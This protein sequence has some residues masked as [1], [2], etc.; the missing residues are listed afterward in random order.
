MRTDTLRYVILAGIVAA[1]TVGSAQTVVVEDLGSPQGHITRAAD[2]NDAGQVVGRGGPLWAGDQVKGFIRDAGGFRYLPTLGGGETWATRINAVG[3]VIGWGRVVVD[4]G[5]PPWHGFY[6]DKQSGIVD[7]GT[8]YG[9]RGY[10]EAKDINNLGQ[11]TGYAYACY[12]MCPYPMVWEKGM[13]LQ[14]LPNY[15]MYTWGEGINDL[16]TIIANRTSGTSRSL[17]WR[18]GLTGYEG[19]V[20]L[21]GTSDSRG[22]LVLQ[23]NRVGQ[24]LGHLTEADG[25]VK[26]YL[27]DEGSITLLPFPGYHLVGSAHLNNLGQVVAKVQQTVRD[28]VV[29]SIVLWDGEKVVDLGSGCVNAEVVDMNDYTQIAATCYVDG[30]IHGAVWEQGKWADLGSLG[31]Y[32]SL[33]AMNNVGQIVGQRYAEDGTLRATLWTVPASPLISL[34]AVD[35][36]GNIVQQFVDSSKLNGPEGAALIRQLD[37]VKNALRD[38]RTEAAC[39]LLQAFSAEVEAKVRAGRLS[40]ADGQ[41]LID[42]ASS[43]SAC[44]A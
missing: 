23:I 36:I 19:P 35:S 12:N 16:G 43:V 30:V 3:Q 9:A 4:G 17:L 18:K 31:A 29:Y 24:V 27:W 25:S 40:L 34:P 38:Y 10:S 11:V 41:M 22:S 1:T 7:I 20:D 32:G 37:V 8:F 28:A 33:S 6:W 26:L 2:I 15:D 42:A 39:R 21:L 44:A 5:Y 14:F 13:G